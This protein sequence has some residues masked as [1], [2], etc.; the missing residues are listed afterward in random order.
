MA[1]APPPAE[2]FL[3]SLPGLNPLTAHA[4]LGTGLTLG[5]L[6]TAEPEGGALRAALAARR[7]PPGA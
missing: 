3:S 4:L 2:A 1:E 5:E 6:V 7:V